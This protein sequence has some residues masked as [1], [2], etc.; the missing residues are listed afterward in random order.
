MNEPGARIV[1]IHGTSD[2]RAGVSPSSAARNLMTVA[3][4]VRSS[5]GNRFGATTLH[6]GKN[7]GFQGFASVVNRSALSNHLAPLSDQMH[8]RRHPPAR[9]PH[10]PSW[11]PSPNPP[12]LKV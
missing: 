2:H 7:P 12:S 1:A 4:R 11:K 5:G 3:S 10:R 8:Q 6:G 9:R